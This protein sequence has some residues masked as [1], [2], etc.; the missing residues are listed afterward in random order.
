MKWFS[1]NW[2]K[3]LLEKP[4]GNVEWI[5]TIICRAKG[6]PAGVWWYNINGSEPDMHCKNCGEDLG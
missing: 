4:K 5:R 2:Y 6:H 3:Y 1:Y